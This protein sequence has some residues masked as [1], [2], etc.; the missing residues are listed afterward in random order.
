MYLILLKVEKKIIFETLKNHLEVEDFIIEIEEQFGEIEK[1]KSVFISGDNDKI[2]NLHEL[3][4]DEFFFKY[5][6]AKNR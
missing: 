3:I 5:Q 4:T 1:D 6:W 2:E